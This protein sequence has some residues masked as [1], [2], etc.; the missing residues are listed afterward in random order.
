MEMEGKPQVSITLLSGGTGTPKLLLGVRE[1]LDDKMLTII[2]NTGDDDIFFGLLVSPDIDSLIYLFSNQLDLEKFWGVEDETYNTLQQLGLMK[3]PT[4][5]HLGDKDLALHLTRNRL[6]SSGYTLT[7]AINEICIKLEI[8]AKIVPMT[9]EPVKT[10]MLNEKNERLSF[11]EYT[12]KFREQIP[13]KA[14]HY[15]GSEK[16]KATKE[17]INA[18]KN[19]NVIILGPSNPITS[20]GPMLALSEIKNALIKSKAKVIA[21]SPLDSGKAFSGPAVR[22]LKELGYEASSLGIAN[23]YKDFLDVLVISSNDSKLSESIQDLG[24]KV[25][26]SNISL[27]TKTEQINLAKIILKEVGIIF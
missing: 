10:T 20:V 1:L 11:Q 15:E 6:L 13:V 2:G 9:D 17:A 12:V 23:L 18:I 4:W 5:F 21:V 26:C 22:L 25:I 3:E 24:I 27:K 16:A 19:A 14:V 7:E 8:T